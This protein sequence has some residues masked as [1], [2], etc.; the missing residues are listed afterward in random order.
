[1]IFLFHSPSMGDYMRELTHLA[2]FQFFY[3]LSDTSAAKNLPE[4]K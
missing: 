1:M 3:S 4:T 2:Y